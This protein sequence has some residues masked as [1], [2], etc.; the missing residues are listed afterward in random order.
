MKA[1]LIIKDLRT[2]AGMTQTELGEKVGV[3]KAAVQKWESGQ[4]QKKSTP[5]GAL[6]QLLIPTIT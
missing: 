5:K 6:A 2:R 3:K 1:G 4:T